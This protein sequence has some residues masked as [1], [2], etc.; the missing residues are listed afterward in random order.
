[1]KK[2]KHF[3]N[4]CIKSRSKILTIINAKRSTILKNVKKLKKVKTFE[5]I[6][7]KIMSKILMINAKR[8][9]SFE[10][11]Q[12]FWKRSNILR[13]HALKVG[14]NF[15]RLIYIMQRGPQFWKRSKF[16]KK[17]KFF[18]NSRINSKSKI[19]TINAKRSKMLKKVHNFEK[20]QT[21]WEFT[22]KK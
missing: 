14:P 17:V 8:S 1:M 7:I 18:E 11:C 13:I 16:L 12:N 22:H 19:L 15:W 5:N 4:S 9:T 2:V 20:G 6:R 10:K 21:F 3:Q